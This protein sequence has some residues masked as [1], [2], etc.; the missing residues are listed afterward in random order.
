MWYALGSLKSRDNSSR[1]SSSFLPLPIL[2]SNFTI[3][4]NNDPNMGA[5]MSSLSSRTSTK[6][7]TEATSV[8]AASSA[9][10][11]FTSEFRLLNLSTDVLTLVLNFLNDESLTSVRRTC[12]ALDR[13]TF[14]RFA[15][16]Y[17]AHI[18][19]FIFTPDA[20]ERLKEI[21]QNAPR[22]RERIRQVT[23][24][25][26]YLED[27]TIYDMNIV[28][29][30]NESEEAA[31]FSTEFAYLR[32]DDLMCPT[33]SLLHRV[34]VDLQRLPQS[35]AVSLDLT[36][37]FCNT[38]LCTHS[39]LATWF[40][41]VTSRTK[42]DSLSVACD[43]FSGMDDILEHD[44]ANL[45]AS[46]S[47]IHTLKTYIHA[48]QS[49]ESENQQPLLTKILRSSKDLRHLEINITMWWHEEVST[50]RSCDL[51]KVPSE[52][53]WAVNYSKLE[54]LTLIHMSISEKD[55]GHILQRCRSTLT[56]LKLR[57]V[58]LSS[59][60]AGWKRIGEILCKAPKLGYLQLQIIYASADVSGYTF[61]ACTEVKDGEPPGITIHGRE[62]VVRASKRL[63]RLGVS[64]FEQLS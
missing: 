64:L 22:L 39:L 62:N 44:E 36:N 31:R 40:S 24:T 18:Y 37:R 1:F 9:D 21:L 60:D 58:R 54:S 35:I 59:G 61:F 15:D 6:A 19:C 25:D 2:S 42:I 49:R 23:L 56:Y 28:I 16:Q 33:S 30:E 29:N 63:S 7:I 52:V 55:L 11:F 34:L 51:L 20:L 17:F 4:S 46:V 48:W 43:S 3:T 32:V 50:E 13:V 12:K 41:I 47:N 27:R 38:P 45:I 57:R 10:I 8:A 26:D 53:F 14:D 5:S